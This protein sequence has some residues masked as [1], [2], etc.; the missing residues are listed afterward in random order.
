[1]SSC[2]PEGELV[3]KK[4]VSAFAAL[5]L[6]V[7]AFAPAAGAQDTHIG[8]V[9]SDPAS[10]PE[11]GEYTLTATG[12][13]FLPDTDILLVACTSP[14]DE[15]VPGVSTIEEITAA[16][17]AISPIADCDIANAAQVSV[18]SDGAF[19]E[20]LTVTVGPNFFF[21]AGTIDGTQAGA[22]Y[23]PIVDPAVAAQLAVTGV[24]SGLLAGAGAALVLMGA[25]AVRAS[26]K[27]D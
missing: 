22:A 5:L 18:D 13:D 23:V 12:S 17:F 11:A 8:T 6:A 7:L 15:L 4:I 1:M 27:E 10:V 14:A 2:K 24:D 20:E 21:S 19:S 3:M 9:E 16:G 25:V 26:R